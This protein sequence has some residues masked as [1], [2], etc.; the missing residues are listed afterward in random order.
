MDFKT[1]DP[2]RLPEFVLLRKTLEIGKAATRKVDEKRLK[3]IIK[4]D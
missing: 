1:M 3:T 4:K 2:K